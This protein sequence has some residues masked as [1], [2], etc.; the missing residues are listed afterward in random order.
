MTFVSKCPVTQNTGFRVFT[1]F[2][3][4][5]GIKGTSARCSSI[6]SSIEDIVQIYL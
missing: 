5:I 6:Q 2:E 4:T 1:G 3:T